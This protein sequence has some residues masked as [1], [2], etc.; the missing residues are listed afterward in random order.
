M[1]QY[2]PKRIA[3]AEVNRVFDEGVKQNDAERIEGLN[4]LGALRS[5]KAK[6]QAREELRLQKKYGAEHPRTRQVSDSLDA[7]ADY[8]SGLKMESARSA[9]R[10][11]KPDERTWVVQGRVY[12]RRGCPVVNARVAVHSANGQRVDTVKPVTTD[13]RGYYMIRYQASDKQLVENEVVILRT[14]ETSETTAS[15]STGDTAGSGMRINTNIDRAVDT[16]NTGDATD[17]LES[18]MRINSKLTTQDAVYVRAIAPGDDSICADSTL[19]APVPGACNYRDLILN[20]D[21][22]Q[23]YISDVDKDRRSSR[24]LGNSSTRELHDINNEQTG[25]QI[26]EIRIDRCVRF[27]STKEAQELGYDYCAYCFGKEKSR[28]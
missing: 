9:T 20:I 13:N 24:Y 4:R 25:C 18:G 3:K 10:C 6:L 28:R 26:D 14:G 17:T 15:T 11:A 12:D 8:I 1:S 19:I 16:D 2:E 21:Q 5:S 23:K 27:K 22:S 7:N